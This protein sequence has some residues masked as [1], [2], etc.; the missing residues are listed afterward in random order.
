M[1]K[2]TIK[3]YLK[4]GRNLGWCEYN[5]KEEMRRSGKRNG[6]RSGKP[7]SQFTLEGKFIKTYSSTHEAERQTGI[8]HSHISECCNG[9]LKKVGGYVWKYE[10]K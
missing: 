7:V 9:K 6:K 1:S 8:G 10:D 4:R 3:T 5:G 2:T